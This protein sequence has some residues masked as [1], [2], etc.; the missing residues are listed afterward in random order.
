MKMS[1]S[2]P[3]TI[4][5]DH[6]RCTALNSKCFN[7]YHKFDKERLTEC[8]KCGADRRCRKGRVKGTNVCWVHGAAGG[9]VPKHGRYMAPANI[10][11]QYNRVIQD[12]NL[13]NLASEIAL[14][15]GRTQGI[16][17]VL[18]ELEIPAAIDQLN[19]ASVELR[20]AVQTNDRSGAF[21]A[22]DKIDEALQV[23][24]KERICWAEARDTM[25]LHSEMTMKQSLLM[26]DA[27]ELI[28]KVQVLEVIV[29]VNRIAVK[30]IRAAEDRKAYS[31][32]I[33]SMLP[34]AQAA[35]KK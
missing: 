21:D 8:P 34:R 3:K 1:K 31:R 20:T 28:P 29:W 23:L 35:V 18:N 32:E 11:A 30:Y 22:L 15:S 25:R 33:L 5:Q 13:L 10:L 14:L 4:P 19:V 16:M 26:K 6:L 2:N 17:D 27:E 12:P 9:G 24:Q 7:C